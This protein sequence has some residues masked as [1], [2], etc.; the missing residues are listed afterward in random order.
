[1]TVFSWAVAMACTFW[2]DAS[3]IYEGIAKIGAV[4]FFLLG[5]VGLFRFLYAFLFLK[6]D[7]A[8]QDKGQPAL[9]DSSRS[10]LPPSQA[11]PFTDWPLRSNT[12]E[13]VSQPSVTEN[14]T[15]LLED[16]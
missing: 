6:I 11:M 9:A 4:T 15:R 8:A 12:R 13:I 14:T 16:E 2:F 1:M 5:F 7:L 3:G 10:Q